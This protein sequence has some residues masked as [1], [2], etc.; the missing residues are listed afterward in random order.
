MDIITVSDIHDVRNGGGPSEEEP[1]FMPNSFVIEELKERKLSWSLY[2]DTPDTMVCSCSTTLIVDLNLKIF[3]GEGDGRIDIL[4]K[5]PQ[6]QGPLKV[7]RLWFCRFFPFC[8]CPWV[9]FLMLC[10]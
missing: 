6:N 3:P 7:T 1:S 2:T 4:F 9:F 10:L 8:V 5:R